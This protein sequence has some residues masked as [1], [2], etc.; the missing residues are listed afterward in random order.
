MNVPVDQIPYQA[1][2]KVWVPPPVIE[3]EAILTLLKRQNKGLGS[4]G[5]RIIRGRARDK[6]DG[7][8]LWLKVSSE[9]LRL[10]RLSKGMVKFGLNHLK[11][12]LPG[13]NSSN[14]DP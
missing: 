2:V 7:K 9:S 4:D 14:D 8:D 5:W 12:I 6:G 13:G 3:D 11:V 1:T 10:L